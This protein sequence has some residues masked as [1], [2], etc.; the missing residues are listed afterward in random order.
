MPSSEAVSL[1]ALRSD[2][3]RRMLTRSLFFSNS[4]CAGLNCEKSYSDRSASSTNFSASSSLLNSGN[5]LSFFGAFISL[6]LLAMHIPRGKRADEQPLVILPQ[7]V[8]DEHASLVR[9]D[10]TA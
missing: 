4:K 10:A 6:Y 2:F 5:A 3:G 9:I 8:D 1:T 7:G